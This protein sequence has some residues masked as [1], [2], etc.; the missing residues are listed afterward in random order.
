MREKH[1]N[2]DS[3]ELP[4]KVRLLNPKRLDSETL[5]FCI[6]LVFQDRILTKSMG[7][8]VKG[9]KILAPSVKTLRGYVPTHITTED[10]LGLIGS[11]LGPWQKDHKGI[12]FPES[13]A[14][15]K[16]VGEEA[17]RKPEVS[18]IDGDL[19]SRE[20]LCCLCFIKGDRWTYGPGCPC[21]RD[22]ETSQELIASKE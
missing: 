3:E 8:R 19:V 2:L 10:Y 21:H 1:W 15:D 12:E 11:L 9:G 20:G 5:S 16:P 7:W 13:R 17:Y 14:T 4:L 22:P 18:V 6:A